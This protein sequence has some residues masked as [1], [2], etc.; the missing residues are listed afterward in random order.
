LDE[1]FI[2][3]LPPDLTNH[4]IPF[5]F[6][7]T[8]ILCFSAFWAAC[9]SSS[10]VRAVLLLFPAYGVVGTAFGFGVTLPLGL[11]RAGFLAWVIAKVHPFPVGSW[12]WTLWNWAQRRT[13]LWFVVPVLAVGLIQSYRLFRTDSAMNIISMLSKLTPALIVAFAAGFVM[14]LPG[15]AAGAIS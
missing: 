5:L 3:V 9:I 2:K 14:Q 1:P 11:W 4:R 15:V 8:S 10:T 12:T 6:F 7:V 13:P